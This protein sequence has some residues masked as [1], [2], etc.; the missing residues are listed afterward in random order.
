[1]YI[2]HN[3]LRSDNHTDKKALIRDYFTDTFRTRHPEEAPLEQITHAIKETGRV[4][5]NEQADELHCQLMKL[6]FTKT[7]EKLNM[8]KAPGPDGIPNEFYYLLRKNEDLGL[9][10]CRVFNDM[11]ETGTIPKSMTETY[12]RLLYKKDHFTQRELERGNLGGHT[13]S[14]N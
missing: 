10:L 11:I 8:Y 1:M 2:I 7:I 9:L 3:G 6:D 14:A 13:P 12:Y 4:L 5:T